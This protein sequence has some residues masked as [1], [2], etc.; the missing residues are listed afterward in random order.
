MVNVRSASI[1]M[2]QLGEMLKAKCALATNSS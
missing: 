2:E 1:A